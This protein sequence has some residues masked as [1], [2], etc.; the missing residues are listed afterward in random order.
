MKLSMKILTYYFCSTGR[1]NTPFH[2]LFYRREPGLVSFNFRRGDAS[3]AVAGAVA[4]AKGG[5]NVRGVAD[6]G[7]VDEDVVLPMFALTVFSFLLS[8]KFLVFFFSFFL[9]L[10]C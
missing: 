2:S 7:R 4:P 9:F 3:A 6:V 10:T 8:C 5:E 1:E